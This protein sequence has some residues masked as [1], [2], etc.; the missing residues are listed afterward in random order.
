MK[1]E[2]G[3]F[4]ANYVLIIFWIVATIESPKAFSENTM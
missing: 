3:R 1:I 4:F 2:I